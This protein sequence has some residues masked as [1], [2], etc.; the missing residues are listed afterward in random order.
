EF[1]AAMNELSNK[2]GTTTAKVEQHLGTFNTVTTKVLRDLGEL[3]T[4]FSSHGRSLAEAVQLLELSNRRTEE[5]VTTR[6]TSI[7][8]M[9]S[10]LD[11]R[12]DDFEPRLQP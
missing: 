3:S 4:Q 6:Q 12:S 7:E 9:V 8:S 10:T 1:V 2:S 11:S 5:Q